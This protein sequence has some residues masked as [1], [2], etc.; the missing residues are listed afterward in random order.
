M[1]FRLWELQRQGVS[2][3]V[4]PLLEPLLSRMEAQEW[5]AASTCTRL[6][7]L[8]E[9]VAA[10]ALG[11][12]ARQTLPCVEDGSWAPPPVDRLDEL[13]RASSEA[14]GCL[15]AIFARLTALEEA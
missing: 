4:S 6:E 8:Q 10:G 14:H 5:N 13:E 3:A 7:A 12:C 1:D 2:A 15:E 9:Q 11:D